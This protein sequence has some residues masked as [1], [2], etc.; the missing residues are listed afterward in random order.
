[1]TTTNIMSDQEVAARQIALNEARIF[2]QSFPDSALL[3]RNADN[4]IETAEK[5]LKFLQ[6]KE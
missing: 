5:F 1:M 2:Y 3:A 6:H 4:I